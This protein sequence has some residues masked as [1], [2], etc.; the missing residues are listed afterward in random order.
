MLYTESDL[1]EFRPT[2][3]EIVP[4]TTTTLSSLRDE[5]GGAIT[6]THNTKT[7][8]YSIH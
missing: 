6:E 5:L 3:A 2:A 8:K 4:R 1:F 7:V